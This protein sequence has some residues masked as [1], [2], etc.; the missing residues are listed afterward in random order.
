MRFY[1]K[2]H[3]YYCGID[4]HTRVMYV[5]IL[6]TAGD[7]VLHR[8]MRSIRDR[9]RRSHSAP[10]PG[11]VSLDRCL[12]QA[13]LA[14]ANRNEDGARELDLAALLRSTSTRLPVD[15]RGPYRC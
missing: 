10:H 1:T 15:H 4:L 8:H 2:Q 9:L 12:V 5:C 6:N 11:R 14:P 3:K 13:R 7:I